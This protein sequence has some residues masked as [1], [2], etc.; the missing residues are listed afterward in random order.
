MLTGG[1]SIT[2][3]SRDGPVDGKSCA[4]GACLGSPSSYLFFL[5]LRQKIGDAFDADRSGR[6]RHR[7]TPRYEARRAWDL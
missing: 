3:Q 7:K 5:L 4:S 1:C 2:L 6:Q